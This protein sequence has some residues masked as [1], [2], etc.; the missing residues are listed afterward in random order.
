MTEL[1]LSLFP[2]VGLFDRGFEDSGFC[3]VRGPD[4]LWGG[5]IRRF[6]PPAG[7]F[8]GIIGGS[9]CQNFSIVNRNRDASAG[10]ALVREFIRCVSEAAPD[11]YLM[12]NVP[13]SPIVTVPGFAVQLFTLDASQ[14]G[15]EQH[16]LRKFNY[17]HK[18]GTPELVLHRDAAAGP[19]QRTCLAS[20]GRRAGRRDWETFCRL[21]GLPPGYDLPGFTVA[22]KYKAVGNG[23]P[24]P[25]SL[26][27]ARA[28]KATARHVTPHRLCSCGCGQFVT[29]HEITAGP[30]CRKREQRKRD[31]AGDH[32]AAA[33]QELPWT[34]EEAQ[35]IEDFFKRPVSA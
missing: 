1:V 28:V 3:V 4:I 7:R 14:V 27:L 18:P 21:Q 6:H 25:L 33:L 16:R 2:G 29:G 34:P 12:E 20:E 15:S 30:A 24:Y 11:W 31:A 9:P 32:G 23:V 17:G 5:N 35:L 10:M 8:S 22:E 13:G 19:S 26:A